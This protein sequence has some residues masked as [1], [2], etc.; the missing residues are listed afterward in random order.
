MFKVVNLEFLKQ[1][2]MVFLTMKMYV[3]PNW[4]A[5]CSVLLININY[6]HASI[7]FKVYKVGFK[8]NYTYSIKTD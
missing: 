5:I 4:Y 2:L 3:A 7:W 6:I 8:Q 1:F